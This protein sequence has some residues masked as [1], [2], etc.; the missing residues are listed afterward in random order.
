VSA[1]DPDIAAAAARHHAIED[2]RIIPALID[3]LVFDGTR[4]AQ[5][6]AQRANPAIAAD[7]VIVAARGTMT[8][9]F[10][11]AVTAVS[12]TRPILTTTA[13]LANVPADESGGGESI[14]LDDQ[15]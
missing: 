3:R 13:A 14:V 12:A 1:G 6:A 10:T 9:V 2:L 11:A 15:P 8:C 4:Q 5:R 7:V